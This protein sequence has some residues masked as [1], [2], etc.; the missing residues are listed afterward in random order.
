MSA[1][2]ID[3]SA[4]RALGN[5]SLEATQP[6]RSGKRHLGLLLS[7]IS[8]LAVLTLLLGAWSFDPGPSAG[9]AVS[10]VVN[11]FVA[12]A[13]SDAQA[14][15]ALMKPT[16]SADGM[17]ATL[18]SSGAMATADSASDSRKRA[19]QDAFASPPQSDAAGASGAAGAAS[20]TNASSPETG[21]GGS[22]DFRQR[23]LS[24]IARFKRY[25]VYARAHN[26]EGVVQVRFIMDRQGR[27][28]DAWI[29]TSS[30]QTTLDEEALATI[31]RASPLPAVPERWPSKI[32]VAIPVE[33]ALRT[34]S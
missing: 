28:L 5:T 11:V 22:L 1:R 17:D 27:V 34:N 14:S 31:A 24:H 9:P 15:H 29:D 12:D 32:Q 4:T 25:P 2:P 30:G 33:F 8:H 16:S 3:A 10:N 6:E 23:L 21:D 7:L 20:S 26:L 13:S 18:V 19:R